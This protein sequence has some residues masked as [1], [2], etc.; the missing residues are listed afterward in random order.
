M[1][2]AG[3]TA[4]SAGP[5]PALPLTTKAQSKGPPPGLHPAARPPPPVPRVDSRTEK[6][7]WSQYNQD[8]NYEPDPVS[9]GPPGRRPAV[10][11]PL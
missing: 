7:I 1:S 4:K 9:S 6:E 2:T 3:T 11:P 8:G 10:A 5:R